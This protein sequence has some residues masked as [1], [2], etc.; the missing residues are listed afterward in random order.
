M[1]LT[2]PLLLS[3]WK[4]LGMRAQLPTK[5]LLP[6][7]RMHVQGNSPGLDS[8]C[9]RPGAIRLPMS[10]ADV[11]LVR[12]GSIRPCPTRSSFSRPNAAEHAVLRGT[13]QH[14]LWLRPD[15]F[16]ALDWS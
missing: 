3:L 2:W 13:Q 14:W 7:M 9:A 6:L 15:G 11:W 5:S 1:T 16:P 8:A 12:R 4:P 10:S